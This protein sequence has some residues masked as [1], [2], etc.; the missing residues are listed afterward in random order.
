MLYY[1]KRIERMSFKDAKV[2]CLAPLQT[3]TDLTEDAARH[4]AATLN[5][6]LADIRALPED[7]EFPLAH[8]RPAFP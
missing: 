5:L 4:I 7:Q 3:P 8:F 6:L 2:R 1:Q